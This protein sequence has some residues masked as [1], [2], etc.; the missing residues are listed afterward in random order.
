M[1]SNPFYL[2]AGIGI[3]IFAYAIFA[4][5]GHDDQEPVVLRSSVLE[6][7]DV[8]KLKQR[9]EASQKRVERLESMMAVAT[10]TESRL[11]QIQNP[12]ADPEDEITNFASL[13]DKAKPVLRELILPEVEADLANGDWRAFRDFERWNGLLD[14]RPEQQEQIQQR[15]DQLSRQRAEWFINGLK[16]DQTSMFSLFKE[17]A[18]FEN[19][20]DP[21]VDAIF[22]QNLDPDQ[23]S[24]YQEE[25][26]NE[27]MQR[28]ENDA[29]NRLDQVVRYVPD[30]SEAQQDEIYSIMARSSSAYQPEM[31]IAIGDSQV[32]NNTFA[33]T[34]EQRDEAVEQV[35]LP[36]QRGDWEAY[37]KR[38]RLLSGLGDW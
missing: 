8:D 31:E 4:Q 10:M 17:S 26:F 21:E 33:L 34:D 24:I 22:E 23:L 13:I 32:Q 11:Q 28:V 35:L 18:R 14:L 12:D 7:S 1:K 16:D 5:L 25:R 30:L 9:L 15:L 29:A 6:T 27:D 37:Q 20:G 3:G 36:Q 38:Q 2:T 19:E